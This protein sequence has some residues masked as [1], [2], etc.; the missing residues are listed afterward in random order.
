LAWVEQLLVVRTY[1][2][3]QNIITAG[4]ASNELFVLTAGAAMVSISTQD[5]VARLDAFS[6]GA[7]FGEVAFL[8]RSPRSANVTALNAVTCRVLSREVFDQLDSQAPAIKIR[9]LSN[10]AG[11]LTTILRQN[12]RELAA[13]K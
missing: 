9:L 8:D 13:L 12:G 4:Q 5:G 7:T 2:K 1:N 11:R 10:L 6:A 3:G